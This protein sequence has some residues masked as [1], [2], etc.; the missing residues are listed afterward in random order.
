[1]GKSP[2]QREDERTVSIAYRAEIYAKR[3]GDEEV[4]LDR[5]AR[6]T[7]IGKLAED[8]VAQTSELEAQAQEKLDQA[9]TERDKEEQT[10][11]QAELSGRRRRSWE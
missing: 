5:N 6:G 2:G 1:M 8:L 4:R 10:V 9:E 3:E 11:N 7:S